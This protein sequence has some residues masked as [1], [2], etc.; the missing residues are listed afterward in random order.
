MVC[1]TCVINQEQWGSEFDQINIDLHIVLCVI[2]CFNLHIVFDIHIV[3]WYNYYFVS[4]VDSKLYTALFFVFHP[5]F[6]SLW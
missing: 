6:N 2:H 4:H 1:H 5:V 3:F